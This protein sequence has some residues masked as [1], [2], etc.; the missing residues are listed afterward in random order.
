MEKKKKVRIAWE[1]LNK[2]YQGHDKVTSFNLQSKDFDNLSI[3]E[4]E[5]MKD[6]LS[7]VSN[8]VNQINSRKAE[9]HLIVFSILGGFAWLCKVLIDFGVSRQFILWYL[10]GLMM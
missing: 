7:K 3:K 9:V 5:S 6:F 10:I 8:I 4:S 1:I 2:C